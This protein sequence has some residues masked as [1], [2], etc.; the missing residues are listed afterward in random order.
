ILFFFQHGIL[1]PVY[2]PFPIIATHKYNWKRMNF[3]SLNEG[4]RF[5]KLIEGAKATGKY[6]KGLSIFHQH[7]FPNKK[8]VEM[9]KAF[10][11]DKVICLGFERQVDIYTDRFSS[12]PF[13]TFVSGFHNAGTAAGHHSK[14]LFGDQK[15]GF[16]SHF[17]IWVLF[18]GTC[19]TKQ[20]HA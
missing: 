13:C 6:Y 14:A 9:D 19:R 12:C 16:F 20:G 15:S 5:E 2:K 17:I 8:V 10:S 7:N 3:L 11:V 18:G 4:E 1:N